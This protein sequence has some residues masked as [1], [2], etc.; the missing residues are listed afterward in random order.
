MAG[1]AGMAGMAVGGSMSVMPWDEQFGQPRHNG[2]EVMS[3]A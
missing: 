3:R 1:M 2:G